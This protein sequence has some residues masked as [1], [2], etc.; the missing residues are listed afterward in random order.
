MNRFFKRFAIGMGLAL[1][2][3]NAALAQWSIGQPGTPEA[4][5]GQNRYVLHGP[6]GPTKGPPGG[7]FEA[8]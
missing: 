5:R 6:P 2:L 4:P 1:G 3:S 8:S 7:H